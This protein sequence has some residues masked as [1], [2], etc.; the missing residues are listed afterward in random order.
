MANKLRLSRSQIAAIVGNDPEA[1]KQ[2]EKL[3]SGFNEM[4]TN[5]A[6][7]DDDISA[8]RSVANG[9]NIRAIRIEGQSLQV[10]AW[11]GL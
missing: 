10:M 9:A 1:I 4:T 6:G 5:N 8:A 11:L 2:L 3:F 7:F